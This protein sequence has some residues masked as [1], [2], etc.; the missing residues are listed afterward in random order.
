VI[1]IL[2]AV[3]LAACWFSAREAARVDPVKALRDE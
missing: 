3:V 1:A 2:G